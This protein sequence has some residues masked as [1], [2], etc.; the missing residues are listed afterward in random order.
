MEISISQQ[1]LR[2]AGSWCRHPDPG[3]FLSELSAWGKHLGFIH[4][5]LF[6]RT[7]P[8]H[9][10]F[11]SGAPAASWLVEIWVLLNCFCLVEKQNIYLGQPY[12]LG[13]LVPPKAALV[14]PQPLQV[15]RTVG[16][17]TSPRWG[18]KPL[19]LLSV[20]FLS[21]CRQLLGL[22]CSSLSL[23]T[24][25]TPGTMAQVTNLPILWQETPL[26]HTRV[27][28]GKVQS[29]HTPG[30]ASSLF[31]LPAQ[32]HFVAWTRSVDTMLERN[33]TF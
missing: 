8:Y 24:V 23:L 10:C 9:L 6:W 25:L 32:S 3:W 28:L 19:V 29:T 15:V 21:S 11:C 30:P 1:C 20:V 33:C 18:S 13:R 17:M 22:S 5:C 12:D 4:H 26:V 2:Q 14:P 27:D 31:M 16:T 7:T